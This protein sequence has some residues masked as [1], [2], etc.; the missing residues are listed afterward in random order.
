MRIV[1]RESW[2]VDRQDGNRGSINNTRSTIND[3]G[4]W[5]GVREPAG[6]QA[7]NVKRYALSVDNL[8][9]C[10]QNGGDG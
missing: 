9:G 8:F 5:I 4:W 3:N 10:L 1:D 2:I 6:R 7:L